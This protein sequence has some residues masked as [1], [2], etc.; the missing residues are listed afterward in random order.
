MIEADEDLTVWYVFDGCQRRSIAPDP[1]VLIV[2]QPTVHHGDA[3]Q[4]QPT[5]LRRR[6]LCQ[7]Y[8][9]RFGEPDESWIILPS[10]SWPR[11]PRPAARMGCEIG[12]YLRRGRV[13]CLRPHRNGNRLIEIRQGR[14]CLASRL[15]HAGIHPGI[16]QLGLGSGLC[17]FRPRQRR[18]RI[19]HRRCRRRRRA[20][21]PPPARRLPWH[22]TPPSARRRRNPRRH[23]GSLL[24]PRPPPPRHRTPPSPPRTPSWPPSAQQPGS[25]PVRARVAQASDDRSEENRIHY[26]HHLRRPPTTTRSPPNTAPPAR[27]AVGG[28][29]HAGLGQ[30]LGRLGAIA[31]P[32]NPA[33]RL[34]LLARLGAFGIG[35]RGW[36][37]VESGPQHPQRHPLGIDRKGGVQ[38]Q[39]AGQRPGLVRANHPQPLRLT[40]RAFGT[41]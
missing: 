32:L 31:Q 28:V 3:V 9:R 8:R 22:R 6:S 7:T 37:G 33:K 40:A 26:R 12:Q 34:L 39:P 17:L 41:N 11:V 2:G 16:R 13:A 1:Y 29:H 25:D 5:L 19:R 10:L 38:V 23:P 24:V 35:V 21:R 27:G 4:D 14:K 15:H 36:G 30:T 20:C 18:F